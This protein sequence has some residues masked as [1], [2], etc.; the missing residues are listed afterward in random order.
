[1]KIPMERRLE[2]QTDHERKIVQIVAVTTPTFAIYYEP[3]DETVWSAQVMCWALCEETKVNNAID[4]E[5]PSPR[6]FVVGL[7]EMAGA[8]L[9]FADDACETDWGQFLCYAGKQTDD[10]AS[11]AEG[12][13]QDEADRRRK[14]FVRSENSEHRE[15]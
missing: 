14:Q 5:I 7:V 4:E 10:R 15:R 12:W 3:E 2:H 13:Q 9:E 8:D 11:L 1:M 6:R